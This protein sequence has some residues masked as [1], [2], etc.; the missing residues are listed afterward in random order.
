MGRSLYM[1]HSYRRRLGRSFDDMR[2]NGLA[3]ASRREVPAPRVA[4]IPVPHV[5]QEIRGAL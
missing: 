4:L 5:L 3:T 2:K 1:S